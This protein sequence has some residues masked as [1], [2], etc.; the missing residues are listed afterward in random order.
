MTNPLKGRKPR[1]L[2]PG[3]PYWL[4]PVEPPTFYEENTV[5]NTETPRPIPPVPYIDLIYVGIIVDE[6]GT[7]KIHGW[8]PS[9]E[10]FENGPAHVTVVEV[11][12]AKRIR[13]IPMNEN[14][15]SLEPFISDPHVVGTARCLA[16]D[17]GWVAVVPDGTNLGALECPK[18]GKQYSSVEP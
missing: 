14:G 6:D 12:R 2:Q 18:C 1:Q 13:E 8:S 4:N 3:E 17:H 7:P 5:N 16:C 9:S 10:A 11:D 15:V